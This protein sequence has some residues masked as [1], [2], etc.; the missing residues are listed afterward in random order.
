[1]AGLGDY[2]HSP[3]GR[4]IL[5]SSSCMVLTWRQMSR[6]WLVMSGEGLLRPC[7]AAVVK[8]GI[9]V[10]FSDARGAAGSFLGGLLD[11]LSI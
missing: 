7:S 3:V 10:K 9:N 1:M 6:G 11:V 4:Y 8:D 2:P 5:N